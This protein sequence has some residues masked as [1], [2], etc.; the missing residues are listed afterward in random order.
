MSPTEL[1]APRS[2]NSVEPENLPPKDPQEER[3]HRQLVEEN[4][5][6]YFKAMKQ[7]ERELE[8]KKIENIKKDKRLTELKHYW[9]E[10]IIPYFD[11]L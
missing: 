3:R 10:E 4:R 5:R 2:E 8:Q 1:N 9:E 7:K 6:L 11:S